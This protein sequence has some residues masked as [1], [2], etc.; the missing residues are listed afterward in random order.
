MSPSPHLQ[1][2]PLSRNGP[3]WHHTETPT[4]V[5][6][7]ALFLGAGTWPWTCPHHPCH[8]SVLTHEAT[9]VP[10]SV[11][12]NHSA[13]PALRVHALLTV[14]HA[15]SSSGHQPTGSS[16]AEGMT[17]LGPQPPW[18]L[19]SPSA[20]ESDGQ[21]GISG[22][23][24]R[25]RDADAV[26]F[27][28]A[29]PSGLVFKACVLGGLLI[30]WDHSPQAIPCGCSGTKLSDCLAAPVTSGAHSHRALP[31]RLPMPL[32]LVLCL[33]PLLGDVLPPPCTSLPF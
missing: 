32:V 26:C 8:S 3:C 23:D 1:P 4:Q 10:G 5:R 19:V 13:A 25:G 9:R 21:A 20:S 14:G 12:W 30:R 28:D 31:S 6:E 2:L 33:P 17:D 24:R 15:W 18:A 27:P 16:W 7:Q 22:G 29:R 11:T